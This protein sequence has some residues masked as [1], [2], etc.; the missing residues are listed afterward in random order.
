MGPEDYGFVTPYL[1]KIDKAVVK[2]NMGKLIWSLGGSFELTEVV[3]EGVDLNFEKGR[4]LL[5]SNVGA[6][7]RFLEKGER[8]KQ[9]SAPADSTASGGKALEPIGDKPPSEKADEA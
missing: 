5:P 2:I 3:I 9:V 4:G 1:A 8:G 7:L 6:V